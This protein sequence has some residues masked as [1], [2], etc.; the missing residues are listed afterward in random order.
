MFDWELG[1]NYWVSKSLALRP[2]VGIKGGWIN[3]RI[4]SKWINPNLPSSLYFNRGT[5]EIKND[6]WGIGPSLGVNTKW[7]L[8]ASQTQWFSLFGDFS[9]AMMWG[10]WTFSDQYKNDL[11]QTVNIHLQNVNNAATMVRILM[12]FEWDLNFKQD[13]YRLTSK[14]GYEMQFWLDQ[15]QFYSFTAGRQNSQLTLQGGTLE[16][17][18]NF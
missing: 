5:E 18:L 11:S 2:F 9:G 7:L 4:D 6:F 17:C 13:Q 3:Q 16:F 15:L 1:R 10:H 12:G 8:Y 14:I